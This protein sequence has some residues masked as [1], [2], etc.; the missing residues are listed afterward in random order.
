MDSVE[1]LEV[2]RYLPDIVCDE[3]LDDIDKI[4]RQFQSHPSILKIKENVKI[5]KTFKF[6]DI[7]EDKM[8]KIISSLDPK[9]AC[10]KGDLPIKM[11]LATNDIIT[12]NLAKLFND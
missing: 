7:D 11:L 6:K 9:K 1:N 10:M 12:P 2:E 4:V 5:E 3:N 8:F